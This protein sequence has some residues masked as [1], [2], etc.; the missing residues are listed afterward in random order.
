MPF[1]SK[2]ISWFLDG[3]SEMTTRPM[4][5]MSPLKS[6]ELP[7]HSTSAWIITN[8]LE[9][10]APLYSNKILC[11]SNVRI[12][13]GLFMV[14]KPVNRELDFMVVIRYPVVNL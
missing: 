12:T 3:E 10:V 2:S 6:M 8:G 14:K 5:P 1:K 9:Q 13:F 4:E 7:S 11:H